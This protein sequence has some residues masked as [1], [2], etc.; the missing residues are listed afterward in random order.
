MMVIKVRE[1]WIEIVERERIIE[2]NSLEE[3]MDEELELGEGEEVSTELQ[4]NSINHEVLEEDNDENEN[5]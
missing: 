3:A 4:N 1:T 2:A 5:N